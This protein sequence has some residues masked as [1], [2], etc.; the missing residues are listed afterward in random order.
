MNCTLLNLMVYEL[1]L[2]ETVLFLFI[3]VLGAGTL[4][5]LQSFL[6]CIKYIIL[7]FKKKKK[8]KKVPGWKMHSAASR[9]YVPAERR[10]RWGCGRAQVSPGRGWHDTV[11]HASGDC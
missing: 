6:K 3:V 11:T 10:C 1:H 9:R 5:H 8:K 2:N 4:W 7:E